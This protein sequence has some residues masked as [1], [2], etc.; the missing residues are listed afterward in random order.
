VIDLHT[1]VLP[2]IDDGARDLGQSIELARAAVEAGVRRLAATPHVRDDYPTTADAIHQGVAELRAT[3]AAEGIELDV[4][5]GAEIALDRLDDL[6]E[7]EL[8]R[9]GLA[10]NGRLLL[11]ETPYQGWP[12]RLPQQL[13]DLQLA[14]FTPV[15]AHPERNPEIHRDP[16]RLEELVRKG[17]LVQL[18]AGSLAGAW[19]RASR[20]T[21]LELLDL[22]LAHLAASDLHGWPSPGLDAVAAALGDDLLSRW[23]T[24]D[25]PSA[26]VRGDELPARP[27]RRPRWRLRRR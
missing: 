20:A 9:L 7:A 24:T 25:V 22:G 14:G 10:G 6:D 23:L 16:S 17:V 3:L 18:T 2:G 4:L 12:L 1:H 26:L 5:P 19:G 11:I 8:R 27:E 13:F 21:G 15:L